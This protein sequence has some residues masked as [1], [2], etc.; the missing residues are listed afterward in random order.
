MF[1]KDVMKKNPVTIGVEAS[2]LEA[3]KL[4]QK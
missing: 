4:M 1:V 2:V 3:K